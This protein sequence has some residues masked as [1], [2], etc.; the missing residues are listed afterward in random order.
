MTAAVVLGVTAGCSS[1][2]AN[3]DGGPGSGG[4]GG[5]VHCR[6]VSDAGTNCSCSSAGTNSLSECSGASVASTDHGYCC[7]GGGFCTCFRTACVNVPSIGYCECGDP[8]DD[9]NPR[10]DS[11]LQPAGGICCLDTGLHPS[12]C[13]CNN[14]VTSCP[15]GMAQVTSCSL[16]DVM[17]CRADETVVDR[18]N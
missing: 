8:F 6:P 2:S 3:R 1:S 12:S 5:A 15:S 10:V 16:A 17:N 7:S 18:C 11:C 14:T 4:T 9:T 13:W